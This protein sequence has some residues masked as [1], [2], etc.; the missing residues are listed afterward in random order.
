MTANTSL[1]RAAARECSLCEQGPAPIEVRC[2]HSNAN[3]AALWLQQKHYAAARSLC[4]KGDITIELPG[5]C[6]KWAL[7]VDADQCPDYDCVV[8][9]VLAASCSRDAVD[10]FSE[11]SPND[12]GPPI[13]WPNLFDTG[14]IEERA[15]PL[16]VPQHFRHLA[17]AIT[18]CLTR[19]NARG[20]A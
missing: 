13:R 5:R 8:V 6:L 15:M 11:R 16:T 17:R 3:R 10:F 9:V 14:A 12:F 2:R 4:S 20:T 7:R 18:A 1:A 19:I